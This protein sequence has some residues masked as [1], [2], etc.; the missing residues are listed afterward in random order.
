MLKALHGTGFS[1]EQHLHRQRR[2]S[3]RTFG[4]GSRAA[5][6]V[7]HIRKELREIEE[8][9]G[10]LAEWIDVVIL[11]LDG[12]W[13]TGAT[14][15]Q[16]IDALVAKQTKNEARTWPDWRTAPADRAIEHD[17]ADEPVDDNTYFVMR[18]AG[19]AVFV[20]HGPFFVSQGGLTED[21]GK[22][23]KRI[24]AGS[25]KHARQ[26]GESLLP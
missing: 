2:F 15:A 23:W 14:P 4:P 16:I 7:D 6:V 24:R 3:E 22:N 13:R 1:F 5:G 17:R 25:L 12:A 21:W 8:A 26:V 19:G 18:N 20:K 11:A 9:P 10:D